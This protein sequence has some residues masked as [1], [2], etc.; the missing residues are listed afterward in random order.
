MVSLLCLPT[1]FPTPLFDQ[2]LSIRFN[3]GFGFVV[4]RFEKEWDSKDGE[5]NSFGGGGMGIGEDFIH[6]FQQVLFAN[7]PV[8]S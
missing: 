3:K 7:V 6:G 4:M 5:C 8:G 1:L 2:S